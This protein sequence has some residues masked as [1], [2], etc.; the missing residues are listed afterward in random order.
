MDA[1]VVTTGNIVRGHSSD[2]G[3]VFNERGAYFVS[4]CTRNK[5]G[6]MRDQSE[7]E[8]HNKEVVQ[9]YWDGKWN[10]RRPEILDELQTRDVVYH[11]TS[12]NMNGIEEYKQ[13]YEMFLSAFHDTHIE[14]EDLIA[15]GDKVM[16]RVLLRATHGGE[17]EGIPPTGKTLAARA[18]TVFRIV[19][20]KIVEEWEILDEL[21]MMQQL[22]MELRPKDG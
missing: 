16:S 11:G 17:L 3:C 19:E 12:M 2:S 1:Q 5:G 4:E 13:V 20:G 10:A 9:R 22:G 8:A 15:E 21:G 14:V 18:F 6:K 7:V